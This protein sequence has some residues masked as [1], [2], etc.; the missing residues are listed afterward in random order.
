MYG[1]QHAQYI[2]S[3]PCVHAA[4]PGA[5]LEITQYQP[6]PGVLVGNAP[7]VHLAGGGVLTG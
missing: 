3:S 6:F 2:P 4:H 1:C 5:H 7:R